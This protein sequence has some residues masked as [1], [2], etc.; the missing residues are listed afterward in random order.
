MNRKITSQYQA[1]A[2]IFKALSHP[3]R[4]FILHTIKEK[5]YSVSQLAKMVGIDISTMSKHLDLLK[6]YKLIGGIKERNTV[7]YQ[8]TI[9]CLFDFIRC[10]RKMIDCSPECQQLQCVP[11]KLNQ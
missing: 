6:R 9:P 7:Y 2:E 8:L 3:T 5:S 1:E 10:A 11:K 4:L